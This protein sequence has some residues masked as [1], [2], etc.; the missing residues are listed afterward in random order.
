MASSLEPRFR[1]YGKKRCWFFI[2]ALQ[3]RTLLSNESVV[4]NHLG[5]Y[6]ELAVGSNNCKVICD[7]FSLALHKD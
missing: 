6:E 3:I 4:N 1:D 5:I 7:H 2:S